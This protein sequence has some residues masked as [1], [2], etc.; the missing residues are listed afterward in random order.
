MHNL[1]TAKYILNLSC[2]DTT[3]IS[4]G[5]CSFIHDNGGFINATYSYGDP[6][7]NMFFM[8]TVFSDVNQNMGS[9]HNL[10]EKFKHLSEKYSMQWNIYDYNYKP[11]VL[12]AVSKF[13]H[14]LNDL[15]HK[16]RAGQIP[17]EIVG[18]IS[19]HTEMKE[20]T[21]WYGVNFYH[22]PVTKE[23]KAQQEQ[24]FLNLYKE[25]N[26]DLVVLARYMQILSPDLCNE[27]Q[28]RCIN[29]HHSFLPSFKGAM[30][31]SQAHERGVK[32][33]GATAHYVTPNLDEGPIIEQAVER[34]DHTFKVEDIASTVRDLETLTLSRAVKYHVERRI[35]LNGFKTVVFK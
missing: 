15:L 28:E 35:L 16:T 26:A 20:M 19:N 14:C 23:T 4:A 29:I 5:V 27:L 25:L 24:E 13:G 1:N 12:I 9:R 2:P 30:P 3:G 10:K 7:T 8:R 21:E 31:Y 32:I 6:S 22:L 34:V 33:V 17:M 18:V 11:K